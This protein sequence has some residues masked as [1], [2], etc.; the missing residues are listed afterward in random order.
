MISKSNRLAKYKKIDQEEKIGK[1]V[2]AILNHVEM[3]CKKIKA[4]FFA[5]RKLANLISCRKLEKKD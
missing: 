5:R 1:N 4:V 3:K 2:N